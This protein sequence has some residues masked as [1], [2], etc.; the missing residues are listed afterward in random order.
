MNLPS[1]SL[2]QNDMPIS[3]SLIYRSNDKSEKNKGQLGLFL[4]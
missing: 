4:F 1:L 3:F 2:V